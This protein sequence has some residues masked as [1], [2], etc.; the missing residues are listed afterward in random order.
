VSRS[1]LNIEVLDNEIIVALPGT[2]Y[3]VTYFKLARSPQLL[4]KNFS[5]KDDDRVPLTNGEFLARAWKLANNK[6]RELGWIV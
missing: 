1:D 5:T 3:T 6:A 2:S 4:A